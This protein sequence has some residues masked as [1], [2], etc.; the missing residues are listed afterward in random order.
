M[1]RAGGGGE[2]GEVHPWGGPGQAW[3]SLGVEMVGV[4]CPPPSRCWSESDRRCLP[5]RHPCNTAGLVGLQITPA[6]Y[7]ALHAHS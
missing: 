1:G 3:S 5:L 4:P 6:G 7:S 2:Q